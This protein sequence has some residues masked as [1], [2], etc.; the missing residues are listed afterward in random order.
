[1]YSLPDFLLKWLFDSLKGYI[2]ML[3]IFLIHSGKKRS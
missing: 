3:S 2:L 1:M